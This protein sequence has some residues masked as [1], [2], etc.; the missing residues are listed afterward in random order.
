MR[1]SVSRNTAG[2][3][4]SPILGVRYPKGER[5]KPEMAPAGF[6]PAIR[7]YF[8]CVTD[9]VRPL[10]SLLLRIDGAM[11]FSRVGELDLM[12]A[13]ALQR[14]GVLV[15]LDITGVTDM[16]P[17]GLGWLLGTQDQLALRNG[18]L[19][20]VAGGGGALSKLFSLTGL[21]GYVHVFGKVFGTEQDFAAGA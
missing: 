8:V 21:E 16:D 19:R 9:L 15:V 12:I 2:E 18:S 10:S 7:G 3:L 6:S 11:D 4:N 14:H 17:S 20:V 13:P 5:P 1:G